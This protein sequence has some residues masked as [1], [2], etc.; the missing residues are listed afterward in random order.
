MLLIE[1]GLISLLERTGWIIRSILNNGV[2]KSLFDEAIGGYLMVATS[3]GHP[4]LTLTTEEPGDFTAEYHYSVEYQVRFLVAD[5]RLTSWESRSCAVGNA[6]AVN[7]SDIIVAYASGED[8]TW[9]RAVAVVTAMKMGRLDIT[10]VRP[11][12]RNLSHIEALLTV[13]HWTE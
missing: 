2:S 13:A 7:G 6:V 10:D 3:A 9:N 1:P 12:I 4:L 5:R 11:R 8:R